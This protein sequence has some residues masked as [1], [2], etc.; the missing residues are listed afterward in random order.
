MGERTKM[1]NE[2][3]CHECGEI[4]RAKAE[5]CPKCGCRQQV[6]TNYQS[7]DA[8]RIA[9]RGTP[10]SRT[11]AAILAIL[12]GGLGG[13]KFYLGKPV[14]GIAYLVFAF[15]FIPAFIGLIEGIRYISM[16]D[17]E[18]Q[19]RLSLDKLDELGG[20]YELLGVSP[21]THVKCPDCRAFV[22]NEARICL[23]CGCKLIPQ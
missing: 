15:T 6:E 9:T 16:S 17:A 22:S 8:V 5:I 4:I 2:K 13:H 23:H 20:K 12:L 7:Q 3:F 18:F 14:Y 1:A 21:E 19:T 10:K 11:T